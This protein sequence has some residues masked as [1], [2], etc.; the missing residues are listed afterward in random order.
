MPYHEKHI[1]GV[2]RLVQLNRLGIWHGYIGGGYH[3]TFKNEAEAIGW[4]KAPA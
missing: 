1:R 3:E 4:Q 2:Q